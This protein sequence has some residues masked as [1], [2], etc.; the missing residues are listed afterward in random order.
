MPD[1]NSIEPEGHTELPELESAGRLNSYWKA[2]LL[3]VGI[4][5]SLWAIVAF[6]CGIFGIEWLNRYQ[7]GG[8]GLGFWMAQQGSIFVFVILVA[9]YAFWMDHLDHRF[10]VEDES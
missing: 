3:A 6:G 8:L 2:N 4:L 9:S 1:K 10:E 5:L 7:I